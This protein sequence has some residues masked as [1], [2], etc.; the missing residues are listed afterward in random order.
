MFFI[1]S[2]RE[3]KRLRIENALL[4]KELEESN[5]ELLLYEREFAKIEHDKSLTHYTVNAKML[6][7][8][9]LKRA[10]QKD[11]MVQGKYITYCMVSKNELKV[12][13]N[14]KIK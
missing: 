8:D 7:N 10:A 13:A 5:E 6:A 4:K 3:L 9:L 14:S 2:I 11:I 1:K 12:I